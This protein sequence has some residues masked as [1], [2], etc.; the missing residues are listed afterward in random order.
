MPLAG[1]RLTFMDDGDLYCLFGN[2]IDNAL[3]A[4]KAIKEEQRRVPGDL[5]LPLALTDGV[6]EV[7]HFLLK[8]P[9]GRRGE[10]CS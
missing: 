3:E 6:L 7:F 5:V 8:L 1:A 10:I 4:V 2:I 9:R